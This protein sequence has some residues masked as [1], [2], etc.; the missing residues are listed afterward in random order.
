MHVDLTLLERHREVFRSLLARDDGSEAAAYVLCGLSDI[1]ADP[2]SR[3]H[4]LRLTSFEVLPIPQADEVS[5]SSQHV[6]WSTGSFVSLCRRAAEEGMVPGIIHSH[7]RGFPTFSPQDDRNE[8]DLF[9][10]VR[11]RNG[12]DAKLASLLLVGDDNYRARLWVDEHGAIDCRAVRTV[13]SRLFFEQAAADPEP[14]DDVFDRQARA[15]GS[16]LNTV[17]RELR[18]G[19]VGCGGTGSATAM[20]LARL[21]V[22]HIALFDED[23]VEVSNLN[24]LH[25]ARRADADGMR[26]KVE[27]MAREISELGLGVRARPYQHWIEHEDVRD[28]LKAC[29]VVFGCTDDHAGRLFLNRFAHF[30]LVPVIDLGLAIEPRPGGGMK[31]MSARV[32]VLTPGAPCLLC[33]G[34]IDAQ[35]AGEEALRRAAPEEYERQKREAYVRGGGNPAPAVVTFTTEAAGMAVNELLQGLV[36]Y[37]DAGGW[38]WQRV[39][40]LDRGEERHQGARQRPDCQICVDRHYWGRGD[41]DPFMD[42]VE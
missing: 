13:G 30:Y 40:R 14:I 36:D 26:A 3:Q 37:R 18:V 33:R 29:D 24:R 6:T 11:N 35:A 27:I 5:S 20:F 39:R 38:S 41:I 17:L 21:G 10:L 25:G 22:G 42:R 9:Q 31:E 12:D 8:R 4:R 7:P 19:V 23:I 34:V 15:F 16:V 28:A 2:W 1:R 32:T